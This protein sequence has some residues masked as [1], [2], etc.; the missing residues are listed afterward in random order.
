MSVIAGNE[1]IAS[2]EA[3][4]MADAMGKR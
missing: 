2:N 3:D 4:Q 1:R